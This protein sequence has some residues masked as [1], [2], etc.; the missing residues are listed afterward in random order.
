[1]DVSVT[2]EPIGS[3]Y[4]LASRLMEKGEATVGKPVGVDV[5]NEVVGWLVTGYTGAF[6]SQE[7]LTTL[8]LVRDEVDGLTGCVQKPTVPT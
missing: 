6:S 7:T 3:V 1:V 2:I 5:G 8:E 4:E